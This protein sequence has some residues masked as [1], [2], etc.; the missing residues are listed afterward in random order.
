MIISP[1]FVVLAALSAL[2]LV[3]CGN[4]AEKRSASPEV[5]TESDSTR[6][7]DSQG[8]RGA[9]GLLP[10]NSIA[11]A[12]RAVELGMRTVELDLA[13]SRDS[14]LVVSHEP[15]FNTSICQLDG[16][17]YDASTSLHA[18]TAAEIQRVDCGSLLHPDFPYQA[19]APGPKP[20]LAELVAA[21]D[22]RASALGLPPPHYNIEIKSSPEMD[23]VDAPA[24]ATFARLV[25]EA[26]VELGILGRATVQ[27]FDPRPLTW[28]SANA[29]EV[30]LGGLVPLA[31]DRGGFVE[32][33]DY[34]VDVFS[35]HHLALTRGMVADYQANGLRVVP[36]TVND[37]SRMRTLLR[38]NVD[39]IITDYP[40][41]LA[42]VLAE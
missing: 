14:V 38:W 12:E 21:A 25:Y 18:L 31:L 22:A 10:E 39:G 5:Q 40:D 17:P 32:Q 41:R 36:W 30:P 16:T 27:S 6:L 13:V 29:P 7:F 20:T 2:A 34:D 8:H 28:F 26:L 23:G 15:H 1:H 3:G 37:K 11:G 42:E 24:P 35:P 19:A 4:P 9:R 33:F